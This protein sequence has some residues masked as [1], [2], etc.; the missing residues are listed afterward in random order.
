MEGTSLRCAAAFVVVVVAGGCQPLYHGRHLPISPPEP[1]QTAP[2]R[3]DAEPA[4]RFKNPLEIQGAPAQGLVEFAPED[5][6]WETRRCE[7]FRTATAAFVETSAEGTPLAI[8][9]PDEEGAFR[10]GLRATLTGRL[11]DPGEIRLR[12]SAQTDI[13]RLGSGFYRG[14]QTRLVVIG[15]SDAIGPSNFNLEL[16]HRRAAMVA[17]T[18][19]QFG[20][21][22]NRITVAGRGETRPIADN[23]TDGGRAL[24]RRIEIVEYPHG[25]TPVDLVV[26]AYRPISFLEFIEAERRAADVTAAEDRTERDGIR[27]ERLAVVETRRMDA[28]SVN[29]GGAP[30]AQ[31]NERLAALVGPVESPSIWDRI[32]LFPQVWATET[33]E[34]LDL[35]CIAAKLEDPAFQDK[36]VREDNTANLSGPW[37]SK[38][39]LYGTA[40]AGYVN[41]QLVTLADMAV[42]ATGAPE[43]APTL[44]LYRQYKGGAA[45]ADIK[46]RGAATATLGEMGLLYRAY[47]EEDAWP[48]RCIDLVFD[49]KNPGDFRYGKLYYEHKGGIY[50]AT[51]EPAPVDN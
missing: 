35:A 5:E 36:L 6:V 24:N 38:L 30:A 48:V 15:H 50:A 32:I 31:S 39:G 46:A 21:Q 7:E 23:E 43:T 2:T 17:Q 18:L 33:N 28:S 22:S 29:F 1:V 12:R 41:G 19:A 42:L 51:Y 49:R 44:Y 10:I 20:V 9:V 25:E 13:G 26:D 14:G 40:W 16:S 37:V 45:Q 27:Q 8:P 11:F 4:C 34:T 47:F 3:V